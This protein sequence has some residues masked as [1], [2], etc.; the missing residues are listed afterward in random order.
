M[1]AQYDN[2]SAAPKFG[3]GRDPR[4]PPSFPDHA[5]I[6]PHRR[7]P[8]GDDNVRPRRPV[9]GGRAAG[10]PAP[11][12]WAADAE[13]GAPIS[14]RTP[15]TPERYIG[16]EVDIKNLLEQEL[17]QPIS[18]VQCAFVSLVPGLHRGDFDFAM[19]GIEATPDRKAALRLSRPYYR[20]SLQ[21]VARAEEKRFASF[22]RCKAAGLLVGT[23][24]DT[25]AERLLDQQGVHKKVY[26]DQVSP[27][28]DLKLGRIDAVLLDLPI[29]AYFAKP[30]PALKFVGAA[31]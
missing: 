9:G 30:D 16:F 22:A 27:Y 25:A 12:R 14:S 13:G 2:L 29:A 7:V 11:L 3:L 5:A 15:T 10:S 26:D 6:A 20:Y 19:N 1:P 21:L 4:A 18:F 17:G 24:G 8:L 31:V 23:L 28:K